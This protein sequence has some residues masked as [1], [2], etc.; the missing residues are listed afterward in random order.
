M[1]PEETV[2]AYYDA[3]R[4]GEALAPFFVES[5]ATVKVGI[6]ERLVGYAEVAKGL[7]EQTR[8]TEEWTVESHDLRVVKRDEAA[9][10]SDAVSLT[11]YDAEAF[12]EHSFE[13]RWSGTLL[14]TDDG[15]AFAGLH[16]SAASDLAGDA[17]R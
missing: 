1:S 5:P 4:A 2:G 7:R 14:P 3:L 12:A 11:W 6:S 13:T 8:T 16:V 17:D 9:A 15:W 10:V